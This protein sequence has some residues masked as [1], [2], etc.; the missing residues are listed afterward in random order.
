M[1]INYRFN[2]SCKLFVKIKNYIFFIIDRV[3]DLTRNKLNAV[4]N[5]SGKKRGKETCPD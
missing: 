3:I 2:Y 5:T 4:M 1:K